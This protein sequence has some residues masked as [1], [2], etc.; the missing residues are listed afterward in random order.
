MLLIF[1]AELAEQARIKTGRHVLT[2]N[3]LTIEL[4]AGINTVFG[5]PP[6]D[7]T[8]FE[9][10][11]SRC[12][13]ILDFGCKAGFLIPA[14]FLQTSLT[15]ERLRRSWTIHYENLPRDVFP[16]LSKPL[17]FASFIRDENPKLIGFRLFTEVADIRRLAPHHRELLATGI[18]G[19]KS[20]WTT[21][22]SSILN[23]LGGKASLP[24]IYAA[25]EGKRPTKTEFWREKI[26]QVLQKSFVK[27]EKG[28]Y[29]LPDY[30]NN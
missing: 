10:L 22:V 30:A 24:D 14:Y 20:V 6:F 28:V 21:A 25:I 26:R 4:P 23:S 18:N 9:R 17:A 2:G 19:S 3:C 1:S 11:L 8:L 29:C 16:G 7:L 5:N 12:S 27:L 15:V 13:S